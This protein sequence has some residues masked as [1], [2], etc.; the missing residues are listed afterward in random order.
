M[1]RGQW[2]GGMQPEKREKTINTKTV[3]DWSGLV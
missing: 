1:P 3:E 2:A